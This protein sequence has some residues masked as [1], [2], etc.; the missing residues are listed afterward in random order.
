MPSVPFPEIRLRAAGVVPPIV[1]L[2]GPRL[3]RIPK[4]LFP[5]GSVPAGSVP[6]KLPSITI[7]ATPERRIPA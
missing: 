6:M 4:L 2:D 5:W 3:A 1:T 7:P